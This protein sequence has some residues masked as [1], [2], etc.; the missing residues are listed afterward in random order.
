MKEKV[1]IIKRPEEFKQQSAGQ[2]ISSILHKKAWTSITESI[3]TLVLG[4]LLAIWPEVIIKAIAYIVGGFLV[5][6][7]MYRIISYLMAKGQKD[8]FNNDLLWGIISTILGVVILV[9]GEEIAHVFRIVV[10]IWII[11]EALVRLNAAIKMN[12]INASSWRYALIIS[13]VMLL[14]GIFVTFFDGAVVVLIGWMLIV[15]GLIGIVGDAMFMQC[16]SA[17]AQKVNNSEKK[18]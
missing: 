10:G 8:F 4:I 17:L 1:E 5:V 15:A 9:M 2:N 7:G 12:S 16:V 13:L 18:V 3:L 6:K 14:I 11:Y